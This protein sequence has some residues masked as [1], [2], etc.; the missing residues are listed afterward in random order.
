MQV[1]MSE[2]H[3]K[4]DSKFYSFLELVGFVGQY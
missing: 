3:A 1:V 4:G 2:G